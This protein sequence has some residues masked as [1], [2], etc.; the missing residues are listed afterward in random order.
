MTINGLFPTTEKE[1]GRAE[2]EREKSRRKRTT[3]NMRFFG[4]RLS[5]FPR[6]RH[7]YIIAATTSRLFT[8]AFAQPSS[9]T[10]TVHKFI[11]R[12]ES[13]S[14]SGCSQLFFPPQCALFPKEGEQYFR[15]DCRLTNG[16]GTFTRRAISRMRMTFAR[17]D[18]ER[19]SSGWTRRRGDYREIFGRRDSLVRTASSLERKRPLCAHTYA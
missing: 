16:E 2:R 7:R 15:V 17:R 5:A 14:G 6:I 11:V 10:W 13:S 3:A 12:H 9:L 1:G 19:P 4:T 18:Q 8:S